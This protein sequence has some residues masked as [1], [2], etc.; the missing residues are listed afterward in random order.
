MSNVGFFCRKQWLVTPPLPLSHLCLGNFSCLLPGPQSIALFW[1]SF[2]THSVVLS[3]FW[4]STT[5]VS[6][7][8]SSE[9]KLRNQI[10]L[11]ALPC[12]QKE[13]VKLTLHPPKQIFLHPQNTVCLHLLKKKKTCLPPFNGS[14]Q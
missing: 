14:I 6:K 13:S 5:L 10:C 9:Y 2:D 11:T 3:N 7:Y 4:I 1:S 12:Q 8:M